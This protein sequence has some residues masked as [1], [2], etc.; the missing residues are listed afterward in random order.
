MDE[1]VCQCDDLNAEDIALLQRIKEQMPIVSDISRA[2]VLIYYCLNFAHEATVVAQARPHSILPV[3]ARDLGGQTVSPDEEPHVFQALRYGRSG[4]GHLVLIANGAPVVQ[5]VYPIKNQSGATI[6]AVSIERNHI[7]HVRHRRRSKEFQQ[8][9]IQ[10]QRMLLRGEI[11]DAETLSPF[12][13]HDG[14]LVVDIGW[15]VRYAS[16]IATNLYRKLGYL[17]SLVDKRISSLEREDEIMVTQAMQRMS[18]QEH[19]SESGERV[20]VR[21]AIPLMAQDKWRGRLHRLMNHPPPEPQLVGAMLTIHDETE[22]RR[23]EQEL[24]V[25]TTMIQE[26]HHR[27]KNNLQVIAALLRMQARRVSLD[28]SRRALEDSVNRVL[29][30]AVVHDFL[31]QHSAQVINI[32]EV[33]RRIIQQTKQSTLDPAKGITLALEGPSI[34]L[35]AQQATACALVINELLQ[36]AVEHGYVRR[37]GGKITIRLEDQGDWVEIAVID[38]GQGLPPDFSL[39]QVESLGLQIVRT[40]ANDDLRGEFELLNGH[41]V[42][43]I[44]RFPKQTLGGN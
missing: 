22:D 39:E 3:H 34:H 17:D 41:G 14:I 44:V 43:A 4:R 1:V 40:L 29:S 11:T 6:A 12:G 8:A 27:V 38:D 32:H 25:K 42:R 9:V 37:P 33:S 5:Q 7:E 21:K 28:E 20:L 35:P 2:D 31:S 19:E 13:E 16:G 24:K 10:L 26:V 36:N 23:K 18:C 30:V 15:H